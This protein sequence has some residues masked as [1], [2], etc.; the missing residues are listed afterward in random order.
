MNN[1]V[2]EFLGHDGFLIE[3][4]NKRIAIDPFKIPKNIIPVDMVLITHSHYDHCSLEDISKIIKEGTEIV[5]PIDCQSILNKLDGVLIRIANVGIKM[6]V[7]DLN[8]YPFPAYNIVKKFH[9]KEENWMGFIIKLG[10][11]I[12]YHAGDTDKIPEMDFLP[13]LAQEGEDVIAL[14]PVCGTYTMD[15]KE[16][17]EAALTIKPSLAI[18]MHY[19]LGVVKSVEEE[20]GDAEKFVSLCKEK[21]INANI[22]EK[23]G[24]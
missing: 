3:Y 15:V 10:E 7:L 16:A 6:K 13:N 20:L 21:W 1:V 18:P 14:L 23:Y 5:A 2:I 22:L 8:I 17:V 11:V 9:P 24:N 19:G 12:I 4:Q